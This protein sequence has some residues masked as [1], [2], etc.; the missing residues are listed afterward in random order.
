MIKRGARGCTVRTEHD[1]EDFEALRAD[2][3]DATGAGDAFAAGFLIGGP[4]LALAAAAR[5]IATIGAMP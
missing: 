4:A 2:V 1:E 3:V 5:S